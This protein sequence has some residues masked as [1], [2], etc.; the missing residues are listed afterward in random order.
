MYNPK[1]KEIKLQDVKGLIEEGKNESKQEIEKYK[2]KIKEIIEI[3]ETKPYDFYG[4][5]LHESDEIAE[6]LK[7][8]LKKGE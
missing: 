5:I 2:N 3:L 4:K 7:D 6:I 1:L 8:F